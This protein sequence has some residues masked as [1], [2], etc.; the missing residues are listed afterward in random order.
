MIIAAPTTETT[1]IMRKTFKAPR[2]KV[3][4]AWTNPEMLNWEDVAWLEPRFLP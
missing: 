1:L 4:E 3:F 2:A